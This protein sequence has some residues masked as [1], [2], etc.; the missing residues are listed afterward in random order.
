MILAGLLVTSAGPAFASGGLSC[1]T[2]GAPAKIEIRSGV[3]RGM[4]DPVF[5]FRAS[6]EISDNSVAEDLRKTDFEG[7]HLPQYWMDGQDLRLVLYREREGDMPHG[8]IQI[9]IRAQA[10][11]DEGTFA[12]SYELTAF[13]MTGA[14]DGE[15]KTVDL[16]GSISCFVE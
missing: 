1:E 15:G 13:D 12:G 2:E 16:E 11:G 3:T 9:T 5:D 8:Y 7:A 6:A 4:G 14:T 10:S